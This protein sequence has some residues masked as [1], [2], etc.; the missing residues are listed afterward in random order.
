MLKIRPF[1]RLLYSVRKLSTP[2]FATCD[3]DK[4]SGS[5]PHTVKDFYNGIWDHTDNK[6]LILVPDPW[7]KDD[8]FIKVSNLNNIP[9]SRAHDYG[10]HN[11][12]RNPHRYQMFGEIFN[13]IGNELDK[14][15]ILDYFSKLIQRVSPKSYKQ[16]ESEVIVTKKFFKNFSQDNPQFLCKGVFTPGDHQGQHSIDYKFPYG[17][18]CIITPFNF[19]FEI[20]ALQFAGALVVGNKPLLHVDH[21]VSV[22]MEQFLRL[23][24]ECGLPKSDFHFINGSGI[25]FEQTL[26]NYNPKMTLFTGSNKVANILTNLLNGKI[27]VEDGGF[28]WKVLGPDVHDVELIARICDQDAYAGSGQKCSAQSVLFVHENWLKTNFLDR[29]KGLAQNRSIEDKTVGPTLTV[30]NDQFKNH[31]DK[32][33]QWGQLLFGGKPINVNSSYGCYEPTAVLL[34]FEYFGIVPHTELFAPFQVIVP[35]NDSTIDGVLMYV[36]SFNDRLTCAIVSNDLMF[37]QKFL[38]ETNVGTTYV[39][40]RGRTT[41]APQNRWFGPGGDPRGG[42]LGTPESILHVW[43]FSRVVTYDVGNCYGG[44]LYPE[45]S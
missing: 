8:K 22:V 1:T 7:N 10:L 19:P 11:P 17:N 31:L 21:R 15:D 12:L 23:M 27:K 24:I 20:P 18:V 5:N 34:P 36:N 37:Q 39:G 4:L 35:Y 40:M 42:S 32:F 38:G 2:S 41:G 29:I 43:T 26:L 3:P 44:E 14:P 33:L 6:M 13:K 9:L 28:D 45:Q 30:T 25:G 16:A